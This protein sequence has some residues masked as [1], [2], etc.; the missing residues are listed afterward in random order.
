MP[1]GSQAAS[2]RHKQASHLQQPP[3]TPFSSITPTSFPVGSQ[4]VPISQPQVI[5]PAQD[6]ATIAPGE[7]AAGDHKSVTGGTSVD[8]SISG[9][10]GLS[11]AEV[12]ERVTD[13]KKELEQQQMKDMQLGQQSQRE[14]SM[15]EI[16]RGFPSLDKKRPRKFNPK[17]VQNWKLQDLVKPAKE[18]KRPRR[19][20]EHKV[21]NDRGGDF[22]LTLQKTR[23]A[24]CS[25]CGILSHTAEQHG[26]YDVHRPPTQRALDNPAAEKRGIIPS[27]DSKKKS[28]RVDKSAGTT[29]NQNAK[30]G[31]KSTAPRPL[32]AKDGKPSPAPKPPSPSPSAKAKADEEEMQLRE[33]SLHAA[34]QSLKKQLEN[35]KRVQRTPASTVQQK[36]DAARTE[37]ELGFKIAEKYN[38]WVVIRS[39]IRISGNTRPLQKLSSNPVSISKNKQAPARPA[40]PFESLPE[41]E[42]D[43]GED[44]IQAANEEALAIGRAREQRESESKDKGKGHRPN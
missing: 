10:I 17:E 42:S 39:G 6:L 12:A 28:E 23:D 43:D 30:S 13:Q 40:N 2:A 26:Q 38:E 37:E 3:P 14:L 20:E 24:T 41:Q 25:K 8:P 11:A 16:A 33:P 5:S 7:S 35:V 19:M 34:I 32:Q 29:S 1:V 21:Y 31:K 22:S 44:Q 27:T 18:A 15:A 9:G 4:A 36:G